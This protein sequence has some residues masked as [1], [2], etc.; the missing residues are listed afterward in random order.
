MPLRT[1]KHLELL[2]LTHIP[3]STSAKSQHPISEFSPHQ[4]DPALPQMQ[5]TLYC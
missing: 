4:K 1:K 2:F 5:D 3:I